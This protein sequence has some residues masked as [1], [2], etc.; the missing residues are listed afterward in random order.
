MRKQA[1]LAT[2]LLVGVFVVGLAWLGFRTNEPSYHGKALS[3]WLEE[4]NQAGSMDKTGP[5][6]EAVRAMGQ[7][8]IPSLL[9]CLKAEDTPFKSKVLTLARRWHIH[10][11]PPPR[12]EP[13]NVAPA[14]LAFK[15]LGQT[16][17]P[18]IPQLLRMF[19]NPKTT[20]RG[21]LGLFSIGP[22]AIP[23]FEQACESTNAGVRVE[24]AWFLGTLPS[25]YNEDQD[26]YCIW[27]KFDAWSRAQAYVAKPPS[28]HLTL[29]LAW[30]AKNHSNANVRRACVE[31]L[32]NCYGRSN[33]DQP[34]TVIRTLHKASSD[35]EASVRDSA[36]EA[37][38][39]L[40]FAEKPFLETK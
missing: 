18:A 24:A 10:W 30:R 19:E 9:G 35:P 27:Y 31:A 1:K 7:R 32:A 28:S 29:R 25:S 16:A 33:N 15:A 12:Q 39:K 26:Y 14:L 23:A 3:A 13:P 20:R 17:S 21:G 34:Q 4:Y 38:K 5:A 8:T 22:A 2:S 37:L 36:I 6:S 40:G 11:L